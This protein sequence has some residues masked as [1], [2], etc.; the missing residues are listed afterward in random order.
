VAAIRQLSHINEVLI[1][2]M[3]GVYGENYWG[4][5]G[6]RNELFW[7]DPFSPGWQPEVKAGVFVASQVRRSAEDAYEVFVNSA[8]RAHRN[9]ETLANL[10]FAALKLDALGMRYQFVDEIANT[11]VYILEH[12][13]DQD[14]AV[15]FDEFSTIVGD[16][17]RLNDLRDYTI[18]LRE[19]YKE[20]WLSENLPN[21]LPSILQLYDGQAALWQ[22]I[23]GKFSQARVDLTLGKPLPSPESLGLWATGHTK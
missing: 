5:H 19:I 18:R 12:Q 9:S 13:N 15:V 21:W 4:T 11:Y 3:G 7:N 17:G 8:S 20:L 16:D 23:I 22:S 14:R 2:S 1:A 6:A 10:R